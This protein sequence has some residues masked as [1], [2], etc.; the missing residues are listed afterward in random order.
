M[1]EGDKAKQMIQ[2]SQTKKKKN[3][4]MNKTHEGTII[5]IG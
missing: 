1:R 4:N 5:L 3:Q 2:A